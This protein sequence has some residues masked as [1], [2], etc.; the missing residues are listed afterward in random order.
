MA[1]TITTHQTRSTDLPW[2]VLQPTNTLPPPQEPLHTTK[3]SF[4]DVVSGNSS[5]PAFN[6]SN[7]PKPCLKGEELCIRIPEEAYLESLAKCRKHLHGRVILP[8]GSTPVKTSELK[9]K[10]QGL[11]RLQSHWNIISIG[12][13]FFEFVFQ[14]ADDL[15]KVRSSSSWNLQPGT[16]KVFGW[17]K[18]FD[19]SNVRITTTQCW[20]RIMNLPQEYWDFRIIMSIAGSLG[21]PICLDEVT[22]NSFDSRSFG[23]FARVLVE[24]SMESQLRNQV[25]VERDSFAFFVGIQYENLPMFCD[26]CKTIGHV[27]ADCKKTRK[28]FNDVP[29]DQ[30]KRKHPVK[31]K[32]VYVQKSPVAQE[33]DKEDNI[34]DKEDPPDSPLAKFI[35]NGRY[36]ALMNEEDHVSVE[37]SEEPSPVCQNAAKDPSV[38]EPASKPMSV[39]PKDPVA[40]E[41]M[42]KLIKAVSLTKDSSTPLRAMVTARTNADPAIT[43]PV[44]DTDVQSQ[45]AIRIQNLKKS[46]SNDAP[47]VSPFDICPGEIVPSLQGKLDPSILV[48]LNSIMVD[49]AI[50]PSVFYSTIMAELN[51]IFNLPSYLKKGSENVVANWPPNLDT[52]IHIKES[53]NDLIQSVLQ[54]ISDVKQLFLD[55][56]SV[57]P[58]FASDLKP[59]IIHNTLKPSKVYGFIVH[60]IHDSF[61]L[62]QQMKH[63]IDSTVSKWPAH[64]NFPINFPIDQQVNA[65]ESFTKGISLPSDN[66][67]P[68]SAKAPS[69]KSI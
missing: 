15:Q 5:T 28:I 8:K 48:R 24:I 3:K 43:L 42:D 52:P 18:D 23:H 67:M 30:H 50:Q 65:D 2:S 6:L 58:Q 68:S 47:T 12:K 31:P 45:V 39:R 53:A 13:G 69:H 20:I 62:P 21:S 63:D 19:P 26:L 22:R 51:S 38:M 56:L 32:Q 9:L 36:D 40:H 7:L 59:Y 1:P 66:Q 60:S 14:S 33:T 27:A 37:D 25:L 4:V 17:T 46:I 64:I 10:L 41:V 34:A 11:W 35:N 61:G 16:L 44:L 57:D 55:P 54:F 29:E 49:G